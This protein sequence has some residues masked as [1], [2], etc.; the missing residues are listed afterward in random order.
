M[1]SARLGPESKTRALST[2]L[3]DLAYRLGPG[4]KF[5][6]AVELCEQFN[7]TRATLNDA[8][9][10]LEAQNVLYRKRG[11]GIY[12]SPKLHRKCVCV[13]LYAYLFLGEHRSPFWG[14]FSGM[15]AEEAERRA[16]T[17]EFQCEFHFVL[18]AAHEEL[19]LPESIIEMIRSGRVHAVLS[20][21]MNVTTNH[22]IREHGVPCV[23]YAG[24]GPYMVAQDLNA[25]VE[26][27]ASA[28]V[29]LGCKRPGLWMEA[30]I[31][32]TEQDPLVER[33]NEQSL[34]RALLKYN[35]TLDPALVHYDLY[36]RVTATGP[37]PTYQQ[38]GY[39]YALDVFGNP[40]RERPDGLFIDNDM[41]TMGALAGF[42][43]LGIQVGRDVHV[44]SHANAGSPILFGYEHQIHRIEFDPADLVNAMFSILD[45]MLKPQH[46]E[47]IYIQVEPH[48]S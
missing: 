13:L 41:V 14:M 33:Q 2:L 45:I 21:G 43:E 48:R 25:L 29:E 6:T 10:I 17:G 22:W 31:R 18:N 12:V 36:T 32:E 19:A 11:S 26:Q 20:V 40:G 28:L 4:T 7:T 27:A 1:L 5:P 39:T 47:N 3:R 46:P 16:A 24:Y 34:R 38:Q 44:V 30:T 15:I 9:D 37:I 8:L 23:V 42:R 35:I